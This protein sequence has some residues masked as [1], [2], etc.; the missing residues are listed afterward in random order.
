MPEF[1]IQMSGCP[2]SG[3][4][5]IARA[6]GRRIGAIV[7]DHDVLKSALLKNGVETQKAGGASYGSL[8]ALAG[9]ILEQ[10]F[11]VILDHPCYYDQILH[12]GMQVAERTAAAY[13]Y[14]ECVIDDLEEIRRR[15]K[16][17][18]S[19]PSQLN[20]ITVPDQYWDQSGSGADL[21]QKWIC[22]MKR[23]THS[24]LKIDTALPLS[25]CLE[26]I[27]NFLD[28]SEVKK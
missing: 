3:K 7:L 25:Q 28:R 5:T 24:Y 12:G 16:N 17:R 2:G 19:L 21:F 9:S 4:S 18:Q 6:I 1:L 15:L 13:R 11:S 27:C 8:R 10:G 20:D 26:S 22:D 14:I 23:P